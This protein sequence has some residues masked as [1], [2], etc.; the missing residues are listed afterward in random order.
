MQV[1]I[2][3]PQ[4]A[5]HRKP[6]LLDRVWFFFLQK[7]KSIYLY[8]QNIVYVRFIKCRQSIRTSSSL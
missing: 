6:H 7:A 2:L 4:G 5:S 1:K 8:I 3:L